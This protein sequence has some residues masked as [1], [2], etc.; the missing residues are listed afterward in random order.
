MFKLT[1]TPT[2]Y[3]FTDYRWVPDEPAVTTHATLAELHRELDAHGIPM[4]A[5]R[6]DSYEWGGHTWTWE[7]VTEEPQVGDP[8]PDGTPIVKVCG[9]GYLI[10]QAMVDAE[11]ER[12]RAA[13]LTPS[14]APMLV[15]GVNASSNMFA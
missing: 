6:G 4:R 9:G 13:V 14:P 1:Y 15:L 5:W 8:G 11:I 10:T 12:T 2:R 7:E 3:D